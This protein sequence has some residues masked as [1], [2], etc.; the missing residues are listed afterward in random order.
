[1]TKLVHNFKYL[2]LKLSSLSIWCRFQNIRQVIDIHN[3]K[4]P[5]WKWLI[6]VFTSAVVIQEM[7]AE[8]IWFFRKGHRYFS[9]LFI[10]Y[11]QQLH[12]TRL[13]WA[14]GHLRGS[15]LWNEEHY[16]FISL[17]NPT[18]NTPVTS[19]PLYLLDYCL[20]YGTWDERP[21]ERMMF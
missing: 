9:I 8:H 7:L 18:G 16:S 12:W 19:L 17:P 5:C 13:G 15:C 10:L 20:L 4:N 1:M 6:A 11:T 2:R 14:R 21:E 3:T